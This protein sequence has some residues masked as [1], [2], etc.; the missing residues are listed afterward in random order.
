M[1]HLIINMTAQKS[2]MSASLHLSDAQKLLYSLLLLLVYAFVFWAEVTY[3]STSILEICSKLPPPDQVSCTRDRVW[4]YA[5]CTCINIL[6]LLWE[7]A[8]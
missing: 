7:P 4:L 1:R 2:L 6:L 3:V 8:V 5:C